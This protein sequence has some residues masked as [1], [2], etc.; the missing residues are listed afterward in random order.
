[1]GI[2]W[3]SPTSIGVDVGG[4]GDDA[5]LMPIMSSYIDPKR[6]ECKFLVLAHS[7]AL[8]PHHLDRE[9]S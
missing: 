3:A 4:H 8:L 7:Y 9:L 1:M 5:H 2:R 6:H